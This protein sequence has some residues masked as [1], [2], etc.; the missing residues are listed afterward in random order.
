MKLRSEVKTPSILLVLGFKYSKPLVFVNT[1]SCQHLTCPRHSAVDSGS[2]CDYL[3]T[4][5]QKMRRNDEGAFVDL[6]TFLQQP[7]SASPVSML[8]PAQPCPDHWLTGRP[9]FL[10]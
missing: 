2:H 9:D 8:R 3:I 5:E 10:I 4:D 6:F 7:T 1:A